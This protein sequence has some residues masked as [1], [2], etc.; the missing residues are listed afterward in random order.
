M[1]FFAKPIN[2]K[3]MNYSKYLKAAMAMAVMVW[4]QTCLY[5]QVRISGVIKEADSGEPSVGAVVLYIQGGKESGKYAI[6]NAEGAFSIALD[7][8]I[9]AGDS[10]RVSKLGFQTATV[11]PK[12]DGKTEI[13]LKA[14]QFKLKEVVVSAQKI[15]MMGDTV[16]YNVQS[17]LESQDKS[18][19]D[20]L[21]RMPGV[22]VQDNGEVLYNGESIGNLYVEDMDILG[23]KYA[24]LTKNLSAGAVKRV[25]IIERH[26][27]IKALN[28]VETGTKPAINIVLQEKSKGVWVGNNDLSA[29][30]SS[31]P[32]ALWN[33][34]IFRMRVGNKW[35]SVNNLK[36]NNMGD[37]ISGEVSTLGSGTRSMSPGSGFISVGTAS[38]PLKS[39]RVLFNNSALFS[40]ANTWKAKD[41]KKV[42]ASLAY[43]FDR[44]ESE[45][46]TE[47][48]YFFDDHTESVSES[49]DALRRNHRVYARVDAETNKDEKYLRNTFTAEARFGNVSK[50]TDGSFPN[51]QKAELPYL[52]AGGDVKY[53]NRSGNKT[54]TIESQ[55]D[56]YRHDQKL[57]VLRDNCIQRQNVLINNLHTDNSF[58]VD[59]KL[60]K[61]VNLSLTAGIEAALR[62]LDSQLS[63]IDT[64]G[65]KLHGA[66]DN[67][68]SSGYIRLYVTPKLRYRLPKLEINFSAPLSYA[69]YWNEDAGKFIYE[70]RVTAMY[71]PSSSFQ[72]YLI[73]SSVNYPL[74]IANF[75]SGY[76]LNDYRNL[77]T[78]SSITAPD[79]RTQVVAQ[80]QYKNALRMFFVTAVLGRYW[81]V[82][83]DMT[84]RDFLGNYIVTS[85]VAGRNNATLNQVMIN[86]S[87]G[88]YKINGKIGVNAQYIESKT[89]MQ[90]R[91][92]VL[93]PSINRQIT[94]G[95]I[96]SSRIASWL[97]ADYSLNYL[98]AILE[99]TRSG[100]TSKKDNLS[101]SLKFNF[102]PHKNLDLVISA[103][104]YFTTLDGGEDKNTVFLDA[105]LKYRIKGGIEL[106][107]NARNLLNQKTYAY[108]VFSESLSSFSYEYKIR[109]LNVLAGI[110]FNF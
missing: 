74:N 11:A 55:N 9:S 107:L 60:S 24:L 95:P 70:P 97:Y 63:G 26:Q 12:S 71:N 41:G 99:M 13:T 27:P 16:K 82:N 1:R 53:I 39:N 104:H 28:Q 73:G 49:Q 66:L 18:L 64:T 80:L 50:N 4:V 17:F 93:I 85:P 37:D 106:S 109:P 6:S 65:M 44:L 29:G 19:A 76:I 87:K 42:T 110:Y 83:Q 46:S 88:F 54:F 89:A 36:G 3:N 38:A 67:D 21:R 105:S 59:F 15:T 22:E 32:H 52:L 81:T 90:I 58:S 7:G 79:R 86:V 48:T 101:E 68:H 77:T 14:A 62:L 45:N 78:G 72:L 103:D 5:A 40:T 8:T 23:G 94:I 51:S 20:V 102:S 100:A 10:L 75:Y 96:L 98:H 69:K 2:P 47:T 43:L 61:R 30:V 56:F 34:N 92:G 84:A 91:N 25:E 108:S 35:S 31:D 33:A 57:T